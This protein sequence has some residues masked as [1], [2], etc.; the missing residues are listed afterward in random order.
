MRAVSLALF[1]CLFWLVSSGHFVPLLIGAMVVSAIGVTLFCLRL[2]TVDAEGHP[3]HLL[4]RIFG[5]WLWLLPRVV[6]ANIA[7]ARL[8]F[9]KSSALNP[10]LVEVGCSQRDDLGR[11]ILANCVTL[12]PGTVA[13]AV[14]RNTLQIHTIGDSANVETDTAEIDSRIRAVLAPGAE[15]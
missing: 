11:T 8:V 2:R 13:T 9:A 14:G 6:R 3:V 15:R 1:L 4:P 10:R 5:L 7:V 12:T